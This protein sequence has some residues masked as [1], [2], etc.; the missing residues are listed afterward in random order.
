MLD[1][2]RAAVLEARQEGRYEESAINAVLADYDT[3]E[4]AMKR[5]Y[6]RDL[7]RRKPP[8]L[9]RLRRRS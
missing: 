9:L 8:Q 7:P 6:R 1:A 3:I 2:E 5:S 4:A